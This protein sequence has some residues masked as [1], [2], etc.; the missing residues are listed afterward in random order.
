MREILV[1]A[2]E[3]IGGT[4]LHATRSATAKC[5]PSTPGSACASPRARPPTA[6]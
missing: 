4:N 2:N 1:V 3:T 6:T 5:R